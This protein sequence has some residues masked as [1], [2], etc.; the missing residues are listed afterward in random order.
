MVNE[1]STNKIYTTLRNKYVQIRAKDT[2]KTLQ[3]GDSSNDNDSKSYGSSI[4]LNCLEVMFKRNI[5]L[6][7]FIDSA[8][9]LTRIIKTF[10]L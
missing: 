8:I 4:L 2:H 6:C 10:M 9:E 5:D 7:F 3:S 1:K